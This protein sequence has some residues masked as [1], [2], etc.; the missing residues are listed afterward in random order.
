MNSTPTVIASALSLAVVGTV[1]LVGISATPAGAATV[2]SASAAL[3]HEAVATN[4]VVWAT[5]PARDR[6]VG[7]T[8]SGT[9]TTVAL[10]AG[11]RP[12]GITQGP[13]GAIWFT[14][15]GADVVGRLSASGAVTTFPVPTAAAQPWGI[16]SMPGDLMAV[17]ERAAGQL[18]ILKPD[19]GIV[20]EIPVGDRTTQPTGVATGSDG[21]VYFTETASSQVGQYS[22]E[23]VTQFSLPTATSEPTEIVNG[24]D[25]ALWVSETTAARVSRVTTTGSVTSVSLPAGAAPAQLSSGPDGAIWVAEPGLLKAA[26]VTGLLPASSVDTPTLAVTQRSVSAAMSGLAAASDGSLVLA[27]SATGVVSRLKNAAATSTPCAVGPVCVG[28]DTQQAQAS[29]TH[30]AAGF[31]HGDSSPA[32]SSALVDALHP[33]AWRISGLDEYPAAAASGAVI[34]YL[35]SDGWYNG[36]YGLSTLDPTGQVPPWSDPVGYAGYIKDQVTRALTAGDRIDY[37]EVQ[38]EPSGSCCGTI[39]QQL[40]MYQLAY[41]AIKAVDPTA[42]VMGPSLDGFSDAPFPTSGVFANQSSLDLRTFLQFAVDHGEHWDALAWHEIRPDINTT[43]NS[44]DT[45]NAVADH[46]RRARQLITQFPAAGD[47]VLVVNEY[48]SQP[49]SSPGFIVGFDAALEG[50]GAGM[51]G[52][53]CWTDSDAQGAYSGCTQGAVDGLLAR[54][55]QSAD[56]NYWVQ[57]AYAD[58]GG[59]T[60]P[61]QTSHPDVTGIATVNGRTISVLLGKHGGCHP[62]GKPCASAA[63]TAAPLPT[64]LDV[65]VPLARTAYMV[66]RSVITAA[67]PA[68]TVTTTRITSDSKSDLLAFNATLAEGAAVWLTITPA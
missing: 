11:S 46:L 23:A 16:T 48:A 27:N 19:G 1:Q 33:Q 15:S 31:L 18:A 47:P 29:V 42:K 52:M 61:V 7:L 65:R 50:S 3:P 62:L 14:E 9:T 38:N 45:P 32:P 36:T 22:H 58:M 55:G 25:G 57:K 28:V 17:T 39:T 8:T 49:Q 44:V 6:L 5:D 26:R 21:N 54:G 4:G 53:G 2:T 56:T 66:T 37:W 59:A 13:D 41:D 60:V 51:A 34:T 12:V 67:D 40:T 20:F 24:P 30:V 35:L 10:P 43:L 63:A 68:P 64:V